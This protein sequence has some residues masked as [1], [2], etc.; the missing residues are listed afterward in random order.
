VTVGSGAA[1]VVS[2]PTNGTGTV[3][4]ATSTVPVV[5]DSGNYARGSNSSI[6]WSSPGAI[7]VG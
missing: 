7:V 6:G 4:I 3:V 5:V 1:R 2:V